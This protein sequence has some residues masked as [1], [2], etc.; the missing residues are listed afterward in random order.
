[1]ALHLPSNDAAHRWNLCRLRPAQR[2]GAHPELPGVVGHDHRLG[3]Q[4]MVADSTPERALAG[5]L[6]GIGRDRELINA[7]LGRVR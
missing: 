6:H 7:E 2:M 4:P 3:Q 1:M 5:D